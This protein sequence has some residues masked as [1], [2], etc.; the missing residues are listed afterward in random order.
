MSVFA[1]VSARRSD[2]L[3]KRTTFS[4]KMSRFSFFWFVLAPGK[5]LA[6][7]L[8]VLLQDYSLRELLDVSI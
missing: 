3:S 6:V 5:D 4:K 8:L 7:S 2:H 1:E